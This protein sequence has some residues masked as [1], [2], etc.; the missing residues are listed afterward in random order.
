MT[1]AELRSTDLFWAF[2]VVCG[3][4]RRP[5][6]AALL[7]QQFPLP[8]TSQTLVRAAGSF[9]LCCASVRRKPA[10][11]QREIFPLIAALS[12]EDGVL[13]LAILLQADAQ[14][15]LLIESGQ[16]APAP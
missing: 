5:F 7:E 6:S 15:V 16:A 11:L 3:I 10:A 9:G 13:R 8:H 1:D 12:G 14:Q 2:Q 4:H